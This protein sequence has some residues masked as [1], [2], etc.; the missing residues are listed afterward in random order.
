MADVKPTTSK[1]ENVS[2]SGVKVDEEGDDRA[3]NGSV[4]YTENGGKNGAANGSSGGVVVGDSYTP[5]IVPV[6]PADSLT[7]TAAS[8]AVLIRQTSAG[9]SSLQ[10]ITVVQHLE[11]AVHLAGNRIALG[12]KR[13]GE[14]QRLTYTEYYEHVRTAAKAF[15]KVGGD[16]YSYVFVQTIKVR[17]QIFLTKNSLYLSKWSFK[18]PFTINYD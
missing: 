11:R 8:G 7:T 5:T 2:L 14:W 15:I 4:R 1:D 10:P 3:V 9:D 13:D 16:L 6:A 12:V 18:D 17:I